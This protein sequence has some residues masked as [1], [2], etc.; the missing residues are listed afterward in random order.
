M[1]LHTLACSWSFKLI[2]WAPLLRFISLCSLLWGVS[3]PLLAQVIISAERDSPVVRDFA[4]ELIHSLPNHNISYMPRTQLEQQVHFAADVQ[5]ILLGPQLLDWRLQLTHSQ[6]P[7][8]IMQVSRV[9]AQQRFAD[10]IP[11]HLTLMWS[12]PPPARQIALLKTMQPDVRHVGV[13]FSPSSAFLLPEIIQALNAQGLLMHVYNWSGDYVARG[14]HRLLNETDALLGVDDS[15]V[16]NNST[17]KHILLSSYARKKAL[18]GPTAAYIKAGS[19]AS[20]YSSKEN[21]LNTLGALLQTP[22][23]QWPRNLYPDTFEVLVNQQVA[24]SLGVQSKPALELGQ[25]LQ[26]PR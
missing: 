11:Q 25:S 5:L 7:T 12:D 20:T 19:L 14:F 6:P 18:I 17:I 3:L 23:Q 15:Q 24:R 10:E 16:Y 9:Q 26:Q 1:I 2:Q 21:W 8:I 4:R 13:L 22:A